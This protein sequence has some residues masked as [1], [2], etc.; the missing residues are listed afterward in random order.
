MAE[1]CWM[2]EFHECHRRPNPYMSLRLAEMATSQLVHY[3]GRSFTP[4]SLMF[5]P[6]QEKWKSDT[7]CLTL[8]WPSC[9]KNCSFMGQPKCNQQFSQADWTQLSST[10]S[11]FFPLH[12][13]CPSRLQSEFA[14]N[15]HCALSLEQT[16]P[17]ATGHEK[18]I[19]KLKV[20]KHPRWPH[21]YEKTWQVLEVTHTHDPPLFIVSQW[22]L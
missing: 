9:L 19:L 18:A 21:V 16:L 14:D 10:L 4:L 11:E 15:T 13:P 6:L 20:N 22:P 3:G 7:S 1:G 2:H 17:K 8:L 12:R 5:A